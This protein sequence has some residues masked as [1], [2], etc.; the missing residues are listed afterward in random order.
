ME[1]KNSE[2]SLGNHDTLPII[3]SLKT[4]NQVINI[5]LPWDAG[6]EELCQAFYTACIGISWDPINVVR[7]MRN[8]ADTLIDEEN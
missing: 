4:D 1:N 7:G 5:E 3:L 8:F 6:M 2:Y